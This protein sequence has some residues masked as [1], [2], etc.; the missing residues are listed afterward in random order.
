[1]GALWCTECTA[2]RRAS[3]ELASAAS[4]RGGSPANG[5]SSACSAGVSD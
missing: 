3:P 4:V 5:T 2:Q 1:M